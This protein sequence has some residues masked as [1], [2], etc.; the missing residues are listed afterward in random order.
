MYLSGSLVVSVLTTA[1][2]STNATE[3]RCQIHSL[4]GGVKPSISVVSYFDSLS[5]SNDSSSDVAETLLPFVFEIVKS[6][7]GISMVHMLFQCL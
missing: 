5:T 6:I 7:S 1:D 2:S 3:I 4:Y